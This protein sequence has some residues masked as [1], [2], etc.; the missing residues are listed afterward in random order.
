MCRLLQLQYVKGE[1]PLK[2]YPKCL[3]QTWK[4][5]AFKMNT[6]RLKY[7]HVSLSMMWLCDSTKEWSDEN[8]SWEQNYKQPSEFRPL[9]RYWAI[10]FLLRN[11][12]LQDKP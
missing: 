4:N 11:T 7:V 2:K 6:Q 8:M 1:L 12:N 9:L 5:M 3:I 10:E